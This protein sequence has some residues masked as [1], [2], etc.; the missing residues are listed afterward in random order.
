MF[1][2]Q[3]QME[4]IIFEVKVSVKKTNESSKSMHRYFSLLF[5][6]VKHEIFWVIR[7]IHQKMMAQEVEIFDDF[8]M[9]FDRF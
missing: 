3:L 6:K 2:L 1:T 9:Y 7:V 5:A 4:G 8:S